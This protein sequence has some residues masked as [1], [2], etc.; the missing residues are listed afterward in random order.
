MICIANR[1]E[2]AEILLDYSS[3]TLDA[4][5]RIELDRHVESCVECRRLVDAQRAVFSALDEWKAPEVSSDF[6]QKLYARIASEKPSFWRRWLPVTPI[7]WWKP[8]LPVAVAALALSAVFVV[9]TPAP[10]PAQKQMSI[11]KAEIEQVEQALDDMD[12][13]V[14]AAPAASVM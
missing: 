3:G 11:G 9:R 6:D 10:S 8:V 13:L 12:L 7:V 4:E 14:P 5:R 2:G 1:K